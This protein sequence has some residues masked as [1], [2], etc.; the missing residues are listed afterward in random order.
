ME[1][2]N[3]QTIKTTGKNTGKSGRFGSFSHSVHF[4]L[5]AGFILVSATAF[6]IEDS[7]AHPRPSNSM[8]RIQVKYF[9]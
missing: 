7:H 2:Q 9:T 5:Y 6:F 3:K 1:R 4:V 8:T